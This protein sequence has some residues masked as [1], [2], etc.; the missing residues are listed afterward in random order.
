MAFGR[1]RRVT[2]QDQAWEYL[3]VPLKDAAGLKKDSDDLRPDRLNQ[4]GKQGWEAACRPEPVGP[5]IGRAGA[6][7]SIDKWITHAP[8]PGPTPET[9]GPDGTPAA[10]TRPSRRHEPHRRARQGA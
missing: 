5:L 9:A 2:G 6:H 7:T 10:A 1:Y 4:L 3:V 8:P